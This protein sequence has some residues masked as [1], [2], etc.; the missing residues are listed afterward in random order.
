MKKNK[1]SENEFTLSDMIRGI[2]HC[3]NSG[4]EIV[5]QHYIKTLEKFFYNDGTPV[6]KTININESSQMDVPLIC[7]SN[8]GS[9]DFE[10]MRIKTKMS[11]D[12]IREKEVENELMM[13]ADDDYELTRGS[14]SVSLGGVHKNN[15]ETST[16]E[17]EMV[18]KRSDPPEALSR[19]IDYINNMV[20]I[21]KREEKDFS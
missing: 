4:V 18:F 14:F 1:E 8:H 19:V 3:V 6:T 9:L 2:Q 17:I 21:Q 11:I 20:K 15:N 7:L 5:E 16:A 13:T 10:E 12:S